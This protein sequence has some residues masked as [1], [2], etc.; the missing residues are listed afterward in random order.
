V[1]GKNTGVNNCSIGGSG[2]LVKPTSFTNPGQTKT[3]L[4]LAYNN[5][6]TPPGNT[7][8]TNFTVNA[9]QSNISTVTS[10][11]IPW[12]QF[13]DSTY[14][15]SPGGCSDWTTGGTTRTI[16]STGNTKKTHY[17]DSGSGVAS[18][19]GTSG[20][21]NLGSNTYVINDNVHLRANL[22]ASSACQPTFN[23]P[24]TDVRYIFVEGTVNFAAVQT[25]AGSG[26]IVI[27]SYGTDPASKSGSCPY[28][29]S[30]YLG[31]SGN[32]TAPDLYLL[33]TNGIC[34]DKTKFG[35]DPALGGIGGKNIY[36]AT[37][38]GTP[39]DLRMDPNFPVTSIPI[40]LS[41]REVYYER[42]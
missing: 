4:N 17:P 21:V 5:C 1:A 16:P 36:V 22:C 33:A 37:N 40:D 41:W 34:L 13:M 24:S 14:Q 25:T 6:V 23:N 11:F 20:D 2:N 27:I 7:S 8:N 3:I 12:G 10:T 35:S 26:P 42:L 9:N 29:G 38:P 18:S 30:V 32:T 31:S 28:G 15:N 19:C 39:F